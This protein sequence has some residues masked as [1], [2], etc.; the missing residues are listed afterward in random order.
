MVIEIRKARSD[1][2]SNNAAKFHVLYKHK[3]K[4]G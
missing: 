3:L 2:N 4:F 1:R